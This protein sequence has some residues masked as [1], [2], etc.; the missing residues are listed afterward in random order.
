MD[1]ENPAQLKGIPPTL[2]F[3]SENLT[4]EALPYRGKQSR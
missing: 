2:S 4:S 1:L 3:A